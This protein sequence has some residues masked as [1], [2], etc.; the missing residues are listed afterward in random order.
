MCSRKNP[1]CSSVSCRC[2]GSPS[3]F[4]SKVLTSDDDRCRGV[5]VTERVVV[6]DAGSTCG[7]ADA[8]GSLGVMGNELVPLDAFCSRKWIRDASAVSSR[9]SVCFS[10]DSSPGREMRALLMPLVMAPPV[11]ECSSSGV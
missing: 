9:S 8:S 11:K 3:P 4:A 6:G 5:L 10:T 2:F 7:K 1:N